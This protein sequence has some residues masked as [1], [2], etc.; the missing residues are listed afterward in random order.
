MR[1]DPNELQS[2]GPVAGQLLLQHRYP[3]AIELLQSCLAKMSAAQVFE[4]GQTLFGLG[5]IQR[6]VGETANAKASYSQSRQL[7]EA[8]LRAQPDNA[9]LVSLFALIDA[10]LGEKGGRPCHRIAT[11]LKGCISWPFPRGSK[12]ESA[13][14]FR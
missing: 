7:L 9:E 14:A 8:G 2:L 10:G 3:A 6:F 11:C 4:R 12:G 5:E 13:R 1:V